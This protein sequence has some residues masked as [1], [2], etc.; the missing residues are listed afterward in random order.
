MS[1]INITFDP[2]DPNPA[3]L[4]LMDDTL[5][6]TKEHQDDYSQQAYTPPYVPHIQI[7]YHGDL[8]RIGDVTPPG[9]FKNGQWLVFGRMTGFQARDSLI[10]EHLN[11]PYISRKQAAFRWSASGNCFEIKPSD[12]ARL[13]LQHVELKRDD[14]T[15]KLSVIR[16]TVRLPPGSLVAVG[17]RVLLLL[18]YSPWR[19]PSEE[20]LG[21]IGETDEMWALRQMILDLAD[22]DRSVLILGETGVGKE[23]I[24][25]A[26][27]AHSQRAK[28]PFIATNCAALPEQLIESLLFGHK[29]GA[30][31]GADQDSDGLFVGANG[32]SLFL[33][34]L[35]EMPMGP[36]AKLLRVL[37][38]N[39]VMPLGSRRGVQVD[40]RV[41]SATNRLPKEAIQ[42]GKLRSDLYYRVATPTIKVPNLYQ[43][44]LDVPQLFVYFLERSREE[45]PSL[46]WLWATDLKSHLPIPMSFFIDLLRHCWKGNIRELQN[47]ADQTALLNLRRGEFQAPELIT[48]REEDDLLTPSPPPAALHVPTRTREESME[49]LLQ[50]SHQLGLKRKTARRLLELDDPP[51]LPEDHHSD[52]FLEE[53][54]RHLTDN[55]FNLLRRNNFNRTHSAKELGVWRSTLLNLMKRFDYPRAMALTDDEIEQARRANDGDVEA[56]ACSLKVTPANLSERLEGGAGDD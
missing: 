27:H 30:F 33:D 22:F 42:Q 31:T 12:S 24:A 26:L 29:K 56:M 6:I 51:E 15:P 53:L 21:M 39:V 7:L 20:R 1:D 17:N 40:V 54:E 10:S 55:L 41:I 3:E 9:T 37:E 13:P 11:D 52:A 2:H 50:V 4:R 16:N 19:G 47:I 5:S 23:L 48:P 36:Q 45:R 46:A 43:R 38:D 49:V 14:A 18:R 25:R 44:F 32:G 34:E 35:G 28:E 8:S